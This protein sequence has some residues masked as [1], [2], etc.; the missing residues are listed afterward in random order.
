MLELGSVVLRTETELVLKSR[1]GV[2][3]RLEAAGYAFRFRDH[4]DA[5]DDIVARRKTTEGK[6]AGKP[7]LES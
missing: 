5:L 7:E 1:W 2:P 6:R 4:D 3:E